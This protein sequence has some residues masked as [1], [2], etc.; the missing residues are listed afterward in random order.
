MK[1]RKRERKHK[2]C[3]K[4]LAQLSSTLSG[5]NQN[6]EHMFHICKTKE[7]RK[8]R[9]SVSALSFALDSGKDLALV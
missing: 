1:L 8:K 5:L 4:R 9:K 2:A 7:E 6:W 3:R